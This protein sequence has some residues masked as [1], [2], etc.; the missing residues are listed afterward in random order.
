MLNV[1]KATE[2]VLAFV[3]QVM[4]EILSTSKEAV[5]ESANQMKIVYLI[6]L[7]FATN[8]STHVLEL[9][10]Q[11]LCVKST[12]TSLFAS[13]QTAIP[14]IHFSCAN[15]TLLHLHLGLIHVSLLHVVPTLNAEK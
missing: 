13:V 4:K 2:L 11:T 14:E 10:A 9:V 6:L 15:K 1:V 3:M 7:V 5:G 12:S 8:V